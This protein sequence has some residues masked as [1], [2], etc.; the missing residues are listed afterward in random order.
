MVFVRKILSSLLVLVA[1]KSFGKCCNFK[2]FEYIYIC[3]YV[4]MYVYMYV[5][6]HVDA[7]MYDSQ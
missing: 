3:M 4:C 6:V 5:Y 2:Q 7:A 1:S